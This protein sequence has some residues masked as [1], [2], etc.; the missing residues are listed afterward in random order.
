MLCYVVLL[1][2]AQP[3]EA[4]FT[5]ALLHPDPSAR[6]T[7][8]ELVGSDMFR[9]ACTTLRARHQQADNQEVAL[10]TQVGCCTE[11]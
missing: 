9:D 1:C 6:P 7:V 4:A 10:E 5:L 8:I 3:K 11:D 2:A